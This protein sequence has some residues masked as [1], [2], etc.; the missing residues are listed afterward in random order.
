MRNREWTIKEVIV[1]QNNYYDM[2]MEDLKKLLPGRTEN[3]IYNKAL[4]LGMRE[5]YKLTR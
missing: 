4:T 3:A 2:S 1:L 5:K